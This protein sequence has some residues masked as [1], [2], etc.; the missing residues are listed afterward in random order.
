MVVIGIN[1]DKR[2]FYLQTT[3]QDFLLVDDFNTYFDFPDGN[4]NLPFYR[5]LVL[6]QLL[7]AV[8]CLWFSQ[9]RRGDKKVRWWHLRFLY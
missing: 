3:T 5:M 7:A 2:S 9:R 1:D 8:V 6:K 4:G